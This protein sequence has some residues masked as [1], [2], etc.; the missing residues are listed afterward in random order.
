MST[1]RYD[2]IIL[3][4]GAAGLSLLYHL[5]RAGLGE[6]RVLL[7]DRGDGAGLERTWCYWERGDGP[8]EAALSRT[9]SHVWLNDEQQLRRLDIRP[10]RYKLLEGGAFGAWLA[11]W[12]DHQPHLTRLS[13]EVQRVET[14]PGGVCVWV[15]G[16]PHHG[17]WAYNSLGG[18]PA[19]QPGYHHLLQH[20]RGWEIETPHAAFDAGAATFMDFRVPQGG[21]GDLRFVYVLPRDSRRALVEY[22]AFSPELLPVAD[23]DAGIRHHLDA[24]LGLSSYTVHRTEQGVI[25]MTDQPFPVRRGRIIQIGTAGGM[26]KPSTGY[27][28]QRIQRHSR[29]L[30][31]QLARRGHPLL[32]P[33][34]SR[35]HAWMDSVMLRALATGQE[36]PAF[37][38]SLFD[39]N[40]AERVLRFLDESSRL[41]QD[42]ALMLTVNVPRFVRLGL[43][44]TWRDQ[45]AARESSL[46][47]RV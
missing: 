8:Y 39:R 12:L 15:D 10:Y 30:A 26:S 18:V 27:T 31:G 25:P 35:R 7:I 22:T 44:V 21:P 4:G 29:Q 1:P 32:P 33:G 17:R 3:G 37:F 13:G 40:P 16:Q 43:E 6:R 19:P 41:S 11:P 9:W 42:L 36:G 20:F 34:G 38:G 28:F 46:P 5:R 14:V 47:H 2:D 24:V 23:Y 45:K